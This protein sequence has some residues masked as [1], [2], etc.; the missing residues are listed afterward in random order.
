MKEN[1]EDLVK[2][3]KEELH[4]GEVK[5]SYYKKDGSVR[6]ARGTLNPNIYGKEQLLKHIILDTMEIA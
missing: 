1:N 2:K 3:L 4:N 6:E 5:F